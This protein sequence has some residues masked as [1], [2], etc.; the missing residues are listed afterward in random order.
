MSKVEIPGTLASLW[1]NFMRLAEE[2]VGVAEAQRVIWYIARE[3]GIPTDAWSI[4]HVNYLY[5]EAVRFRSAAEALLEAYET[6]TRTGLDQTVSS[7]AMYTPWYA[8]PSV[9]GIEPR[10]YHIRV[11][12]ETMLPEEAWLEAGVPSYKTDFRV[13]RL[14]RWPES[15]ADLEY[16]VQ[17]ETRRWQEESPAFSPVRA[18]PVSVMMM[19]D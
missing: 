6:Y 5:Q 16:E 19:Y 3:V 13:V 12:V 11:K 9:P 4:F 18:I 7:E 2:K 10:E 15:I 1:G 14:S 8:G 17:A